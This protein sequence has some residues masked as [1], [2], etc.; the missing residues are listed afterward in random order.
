MYRQRYEAALREIRTAPVTEIYLDEKSTVGMPG[1]GPE[2]SWPPTPRYS[3]E[4]FRY[5]R[6]DLQFD[7]H[8]VGFR[9]GWE[10]WQKQ[11]CLADTP[12]NQKENH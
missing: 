12:G 2:T 7:F 5:V 3:Q 8:L 9:E 4:F 10:V 1:G 6:R 11:S